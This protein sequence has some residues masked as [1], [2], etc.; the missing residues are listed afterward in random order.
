MTFLITLNL[1]SSLQPDEQTDRS[2][3]TQNLLY[4]SGFFNLDRM[5][6]AARRPLLRLRNGR[7][8]SSLV[9]V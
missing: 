1:T 8:T 6:N 3:A 2:S 7:E 4:K 5:Q 9:A